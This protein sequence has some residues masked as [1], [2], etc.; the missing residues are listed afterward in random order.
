MTPLRVGVIGAGIMGSDHARQL[1]HWVADAEPVLI[2]DIDGARALAVAAELGARSCLDPLELVA[3][4]Q[5]QAVIIASH[6]STHADLVRACVRADKP[7]L[8]E[9]PLAPTLDE[10]AALLRD[11]GAG[12]AELVSLGFMRR[13]DQ[14][15]VQVRDRIRSG[16]LGAP[17]VLHCSSRGVSSGP[18][19]TSEASVTN[20]TVHDLDIAPWLLDSPVVEAAWVSVRR[21]ANAEEFADPQV[22]LLRT[23]DG[24]LTTVETYLNARYGYDIRCEA[25]CEHGTVSIAEPAAVRTDALPGRSVEYARDWRPRFADAY[26]RELT[27]WVHRVTTGTAPD[28]ALAG[29]HDGLVAAAVADAVIRS[30][31]DGGSFRPVAVPSVGHP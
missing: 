15:Y 3:D 21:S 4:P 30:M 28:G 2:A 6:D 29:A 7:V 8:C 1:R 26:R 17:L 19:T 11:I 27:A 14:G 24:A 9:K 25:V 20:S 18:G 31:R 12:G 13:F 16:V 23:A 10:S 22:M 5:V